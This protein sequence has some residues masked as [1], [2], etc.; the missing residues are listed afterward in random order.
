MESPVDK[1]YKISFIL[2]G[3]IYL[4]ALRYAFNKTFFNLQ[5]HGVARRM[6]QKKTPEVVKKELL[7][8]IVEL[9]NGDEDYLHMNEETKN[10]KEVKDGV[11][12]IKNIREF[13]KRNK[14]EDHKYSPKTGRAVE[15][16]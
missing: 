15:K 3:E 9:S 14:Q 7:T 4:T 12:L 2:K 5:L 13:L 6:N 11:C 16:V 1:V 10:A 8:S